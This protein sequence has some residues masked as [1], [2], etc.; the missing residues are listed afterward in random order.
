M[1]LLHVRGANRPKGRSG[2]GCGDFKVLEADEVFLCVVVLSHSH[3]RMVSLKKRVPQRRVFL[4]HVL[5]LARLLSVSER[6]GSSWPWMKRCQLGEGAVGKA[7]I[8]PSFDS[9][10]R[11]TQLKRR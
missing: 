3:R 11:P 8:I 5:Y 6:P 9:N 1:P 7:R 2:H 10:A 4:Q